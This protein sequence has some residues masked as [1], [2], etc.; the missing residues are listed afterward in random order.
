MGVVDILFKFRSSFVVGNGRG[1]EF[2]R[3][4]GRGR[5]SLSVSFPFLYSIAELKEAWVRDYWNGLW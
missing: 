3:D 2:W 1:I 4:T 5:S